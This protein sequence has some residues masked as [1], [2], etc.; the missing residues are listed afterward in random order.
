MSGSWMEA[1]GGLKATPEGWGGDIL[2]TKDD[3]VEG[4]GG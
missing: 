4:V 3:I 1:W 2:P